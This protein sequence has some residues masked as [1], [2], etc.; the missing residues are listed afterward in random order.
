MPS[1]SEMLSTVRTASDYVKYIPTSSWDT[2][3]LVNGISL[4]IITRLQREGGTIDQ[5][6]IGDPST[7]EN[8]DS[9][10][11]VH[12]LDE[13]M[14]ESQ[15]DVLFNT[16]AFDAVVEDNVVKGVVIASK[17]GPQVILADAIVDASG[18][19]DMA[20]AAGAPFEIG[21][22]KDGRLHGGS[23]KMD[24]G[25]VNID[26]YMEYVKKRPTKTDEE[27]KKQS[28]EQSRLFGG[29]GPPNTAI[30]TLD[31]EKGYFNMGGK[32]RSWDQIEQDRKEEKMYLTLPGVGDEW[33]EF[34]KSE[35]IP[36]LLGAAK[37]I[38]PR[39]PGVRFGVIRHGKMRY[40][41]ANSGIHEAFFNQTN[42]EDISKAIIW[43][44]KVN[45]IYMKF[46]REHIPGFEDSYILKT[47]PTVGTRE[48]RRI[49]GE[50]MVT[51]EDCVEGR[52]FSDVIAK[53]GRALNVHSITGV[54]GEHYWIE[55]K[56]PY[57][58]PYRMLVPKKIDNLLVAGRCS[59]ITH[60]ALG[61]LRA[62][63]N[64]MSLGE[65]A[66]TAAALSAKLE[67]SP[68]NLNITLLQ[69]KLLD[70][71]VLLFLDDEKKKEKEVLGYPAIT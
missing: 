32:R 59:S 4:E 1:D 68:R 29:G 40:D 63:P 44:R 54:W 67:V 56:E 43:M 46:L 64:C 42:Q 16:F 5:G 27:R 57:D 25:G 33:L 55:P 13:M 6:H 38:Y 53:C 69:K 3:L 51:A 9:E 15:V 30:L 47:S 66:G 22:E 62:E 19:A 50:Y 58:F 11:M 24:I 17:S 48:S 36:P 60:K 8:F 34:V 61:G 10:M 52:R 71:G 28:K 21:R 49:I 65:A 14:E 31:G 41:Q 2:P 39:G 35:G 12:V 70:Q 37:L 20:A 26:R 45:R 7:R 18:D 23:M